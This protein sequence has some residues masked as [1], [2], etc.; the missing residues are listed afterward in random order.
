M[1][2]QLSLGADERAPE[3]APAAPV[4]S[5]LQPCGDAAFALAACVAAGSVHLIRAQRSASGGW[6]LEAGAT[7]LCD[8]VTTEPGEWGGGGAGVGV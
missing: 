8:R 5:N 3:A 4:F 7:L 2:A 1:A 6:A